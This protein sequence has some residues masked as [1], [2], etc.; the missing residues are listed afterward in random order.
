MMVSQKKLTFTS[1]SGVRTQRRLYTVAERKVI[2]TMNIGVP[3]VI[4]ESMNLDIV[5]VEVI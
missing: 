4:Q 5:L 1:R 3:Y 2:E